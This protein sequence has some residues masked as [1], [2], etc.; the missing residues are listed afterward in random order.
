M[1]AR[2]PLPGEPPGEIKHTHHELSAQRM[3][4]LKASCNV[5]VCCA[6]EPV[7]GPSP[8]PGIAELS[9]P[10]RPTT[11]ELSKGTHSCLRY[12]RCC[13]NLLNGG[14][15][16]GQDSGVCSHSSGVALTAWGGAGLTTLWKPWSL[17]VLWSYPILLP[18][19]TRS[20]KSSLMERASVEFAGLM[21]VFIGFTLL[22]CTVYQ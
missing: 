3:V 20:R 5:H 1:E 9:S 7:G 22:S 13:S 8:T 15:A 6:R 11:T 21:R 12:T 14:R 4:K 17:C 18:D 2:E 16:L 10:R 19:L